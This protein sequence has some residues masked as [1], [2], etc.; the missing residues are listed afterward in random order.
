MKEKARKK[1][2]KKRSNKRTNIMYW[3]AMAL[4]VITF[5]F[6]ILTQ[7]Q[8]KLNLAAKKTELTAEL[9]TQQEKKDSLQKLSE[10]QDNPEFVEKI[11]REKLNMV[12]PNEIVFIDDNS[13]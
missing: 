10:N 4:I 8:E 3:T 5:G 2:E 11:A 1:T 12:K 13:K 9:N 7:Y 6:V